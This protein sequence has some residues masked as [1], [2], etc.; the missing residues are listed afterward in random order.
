MVSDDV[1]VLGRA[2]PAGVLAHPGP[3][4][5]TLPAGLLPPGAAALGRFGDEAWIAVPDTAPGPL[6][7]AEVVLLD[8]SPG[9]ALAVGPD[10]AP[11]AGLAAHAL[12]SGSDP[13]R[14]RRRFELLA[15]VAERVPVRRLTADPA[16]LPSVLADLLTA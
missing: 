3:P 8:R 15:D 11:L 9:A 10:A 1:L 4:V 14:R 2:E 13:E 5:A 12:D 6:A 16:I 7:L